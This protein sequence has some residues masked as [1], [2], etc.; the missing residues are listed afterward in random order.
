MTA[1]KGD[2]SV[3]G[4]NRQVVRSTSVE[5]SCRNCL[6]SYEFGQASHFRK[7]SAS[8]SESRE[9]ERATLLAS[10]QLNTVG[11]LYSCEDVCTRKVHKDNLTPALIQV[12]SKHVRLIHTTVLY[13]RAKESQC[14]S[15]PVF[16]S[17]RLDWLVFLYLSYTSSLSQLLIFS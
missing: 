1:A 13:F 15:L 10:A 17:P 7:D 11:P 16:T 2:I 5:R 4:Q 12:R 9:S 8:S 6:R 14:R 3:L